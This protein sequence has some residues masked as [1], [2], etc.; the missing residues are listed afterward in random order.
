E[1]RVLARSE[2]AVRSETRGIIVELPPYVREGSRVTK[3]DVVARLRDF[4][5]QQKIYQ[6]TGDLERKRSELALL[7]A[8]A[9]PEE[10]ERKERLV[11]TKRIELLNA[12]RNQEQRNQLAQSVERKRTELLLDQQTLQRTRELTDNGLSPRFDL[13]KA[14]TAVKVRERE[15][16][17]IEAAIR[18]VS[19]T[20]DREAD[21][22][23][24]ELAEAESELKLMRA[25]NRPE[26]IQQVEAD[27]QK[28]S[29]E[30]AILDQE[31]A[32]TEIRAPISGIVTT[33][34]VER[35][36]NQQLNP[37]LIPGEEL[38]RIADIERVT[39]EMLVPEKELAD[40][41]PGNPIWMKARSL[42]AVDLQGRVDFIAPIAQ[43]VNGQQMVVVRSE[44][45]NDNLL[46]KPEMTGVAKIYCG[47]RRI[48]DLFTRRFI[49]WFRTEFWDLLP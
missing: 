26:Q 31:L 2:M 38:F 3:G 24:R 33:P 37:E 46:L 12:R 30:A 29:N 32:K 17:E 20:A 36:L 7:R 18:V 13:E 21:L 8:G 45:Q 16:A 14:E 42:P 49:R 40:V 1:F 4:E 28:L 27:V 5:K 47:D 25:G 11:D 19:E 23:T 10:I 35:K 39:V 9:R 15:I 48:I 43:T 34:F 41:R 22:K 6:V 44:L